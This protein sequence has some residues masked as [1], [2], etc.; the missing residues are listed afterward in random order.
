MF[1][2]SWSLDRQGFV[3]HYMISGPAVVPFFSQE[4]DS[5]QLRYEAYLRSIVAEHPAL[6][7]TEYVSASENSRLHTR[8]SNSIMSGIQI[9]MSSI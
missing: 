5:N 6:T 4:R 9:S 1:M 2:Q 3:N 7:G 8:I